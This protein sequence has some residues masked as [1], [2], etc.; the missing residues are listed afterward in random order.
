[1]DNEKIL[2]KAIE[3][4]VKGGFDFELYNIGLEDL[5]EADIYWIIFSHSFL[6]TFFGES[7]T[8]RF[9]TNRPEWQYHA[10]QMVLEKEPI[11][12][13]EKYL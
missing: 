10:Q 12:Y 7:K 13:I 9:T 8:S 5:S 11:K 1:M 2:K 3:K 4:A 6:K